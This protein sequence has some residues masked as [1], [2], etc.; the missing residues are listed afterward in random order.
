MILEG[1]L[2]VVL[3]LLNY[4]WLMDMNANRNDKINKKMFE[5]KLS[6]IAMLFINV[7]VFSSLNCRAQAEVPLEIEVVFSSLRS[8]KGQ[9]HIAIYDQAKAFPSDGDRALIHAVL[10]PLAAET[11]RIKI[12]IEKNVPIAISAFHDENE[13]GKLDTNFL[14]IPKEGFGFSR[15]PRVMFG[16]PGFKESVLSVGD[17]TQPIEITMKYF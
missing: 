13:N 3:G 4:A 11:V 8:L 7:L 14:G 5:L 16:P 9:I 17:L 12:I 10:K 15:N 6:S 1:G 2:L